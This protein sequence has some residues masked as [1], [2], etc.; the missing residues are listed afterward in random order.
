MRKFKH[1]N[2]GEVLELNTSHSALSVVENS[3]SWEDVTPNAEID[4]E[5][6][7]EPKTELEDNAVIETDSVE[8]VTGVDLEPEKEA[9]KPA[10]KK[11]PKK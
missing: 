1:I 3:P 11:T 4:D 8:E 10:P 7:V 5:P 6:K 9:D 2:T